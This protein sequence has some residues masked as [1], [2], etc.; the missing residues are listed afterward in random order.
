MTCREAL[1]ILLGAEELPAFEIA[2][3][4]AHA[5]T[6]ARCGA[7]YR[8]TLDPLE[9]SAVSALELRPWPP[10]RAALF[11]VATVQFVI[12]VP[13][14]VGLVITAAYWFTA[15]TSFANPAVTLARGFTTTFSG[16]AINHVPAFIAAQLVGAGVASLACSVLFPAQKPTRV[17]VP[18]E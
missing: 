17:T 3:A 2:R 15:S 4:R 18:A 5:S 8:T 14:L 1:T 16:I 6:C 12:A 10:L 7:A 11:A 13:W 9:R